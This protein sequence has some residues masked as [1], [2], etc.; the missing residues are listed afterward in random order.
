MSAKKS[1]NAKG[2]E[3]EWSKPA[4]LPAKVQ[5][6]KTF[7]GN[8][9]EPSETPPAEYRVPIDLR[10]DLIE[11]EFVEGLAKILGIGAAKYGEEKWKC[12]LTG[13]NSGLNHAL[14]HINE[15][16]RGAPN[17]YGDLPTH[18]EQAAVNLMFHAWH[19]R[20]AAKEAK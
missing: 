7:T 8:T 2:I 19:M 6:V 18:L 10:F 14:K 15:F 16:Q 13:C 4:T 1:P 20:H 12:G 9:S 5:S 3:A 11:P 17:D